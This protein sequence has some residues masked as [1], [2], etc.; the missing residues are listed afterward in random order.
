MSYFSKFKKLIVMLADTLI[1][2]FSYLLVLFFIGG[3]QA[4]TELH[5]NMFY[6]VALAVAVYLLVFVLM[7]VYRYI[8]HFAGLRDY[9]LCLEANAISFFIV[10]ALSLTFSTMFLPFKIN[11]LACTYIAL[12]TIGFRVGLRILMTYLYRHKQEVEAPKTDILIVG[13]GMGGSRLI[14]DIQGDV[15]SAY[16]VVGLIDDDP[17][18]KNCLI[19]GVKVFGGRENIPA[20]CKKLNVKGIVIAIPSLDAKNQ[21]E[22]LAICKE[23]K[24]KLKMLPAISKILTNGKLSSSIRDVNI[25]D[26]LARQP[27]ELD[28]VGIRGYI[29]GKVVIV[30]GGGGSIGSE[31]CRQI[32]KYGP[33]KL[34]ILDIYENNAFSIEQ[35]LRAAFPNQNLEVVIASVR[36]K[37]RLM[38][39]FEK[40][41]PNLVFHAAAHK[42]VPLMEDSGFEAIKNNVVGTMNTAE[43]AHAYH[44]DKFVLVSTDKAVNPTNI[45]GASKRLCEMVIQGI[46]PRS[47]TDFVAVRFGNVLGSN[48]SV[49]PLFQKQIKNGGPVTVTHKE[50]TRYLM[51]IPEA[52]GLI[53]QAAS[54]AKGG[55]IFIL[56]MGEPVKIYDLAKNLITLSGLEVDKDIKIKITGLRPGEKLYE[57]LL[58]G[59]EGLTS[60]R[61]N[62]IFVAKSSVFD[63]DYIK[64]EV[65]GIIDAENIYHTDELKAMIKKLVPTYQYH[66]K[67]EKKETAQ[68]ASIAAHRK[69]KVVNV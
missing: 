43:C 3:M 56:D 22:I 21:K 46:N 53:L 29:S 52:A 40:Y 41:R 4:A 59:E 38:Q 69:R 12:F 49:I 5:R 42:H 15:C 19:S 20:V 31:L 6:T 26:L 48:G 55:E 64:R 66:E 32:V 2:V 50:I 28:N 11:F 7:R 63:Y 62:K 10:S 18:K 8:L 25:E 24:C 16:H 68:I 17:D 27:V 23:T 37:K 65:R 33:A 44:A 34:V 13:A 47:E 51:T 1:V 54:Y 9:I 67:E 14:K 60:T 58:T 30:T 39:V 36:D 61:H 35:E 45:M 57:E